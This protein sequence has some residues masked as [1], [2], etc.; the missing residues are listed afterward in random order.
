MRGLSLITSQFPVPQSLETGEISP[1][2]AVPAA[3]ACEQPGYGT[4]DHVAGSATRIPRIGGHACRYT[5]PHR[6]V[7]TIAPKLS[8]LPSPAWRKGRLSS[9]HAPDAARVSSP[10]SRQG[11]RL[12]HPRPPLL[13]QSQ[14]ELRDT[15]SC[16]ALGTSCAADEGLAVGRWASCFN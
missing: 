12:V 14:H 8:H 13:C 11:F 6:L 5:M 1:R 7:E 3:L 9:L 15:Q 4:A 10:A 16:H 2:I